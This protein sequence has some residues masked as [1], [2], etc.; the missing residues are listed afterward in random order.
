M[1]EILA[2]LRAVCSAICFI[3][4]LLFV[5]ILFPW[6]YVDMPKGV[7]IETGEASSQVVA[8][9]TCAIF[10]GISIMVGWF[11]ERQSWAI[12]QRII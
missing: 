8:A 4:I 1:P 10:M 12:L 6:K 9:S 11:L 5:I 7:T 3:P 2:P